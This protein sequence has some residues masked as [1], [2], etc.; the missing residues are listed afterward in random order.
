MPPVYAV[1]ARSCNLAADRAL[2]TALPDLSPEDRETALDTLV[3]RERGQGL[4]AVVARFPSFDAA[5]QALVLARADRL[6]AGVRA[7][8]DSGNIDTR[9]AAVELIRRSGSSKLAY[10]LAGALSQRCPRTRMRAGNALQQLVAEHLRQRDVTPADPA[11]RRERRQLAMAIRQA[12]ACWEAHF[13]T[14][15]ITAAMWLAEELEDVIVHRA[16]QPRSKLGRAFDELLRGGYDRHTTGYLLRALR[17]PI[18]RGKAAR[19]IGACADDTFML[20]LL[21]ELWVT[22][23][24]RM[25]KALSW[26]RRLAWL[27]DGIRPLLELDARR[28]EAAAALVGGVGITNDAKVGLLQTMVT[29]GRPALRRA[30]MWQLVGNRSPEAVAA[31]RCL[32]KRGQRALARVADRELKRRSRADLVTSPS[33]SARGTESDRSVVSTFDAYWTRFDRLDDARRAEFGRRLRAA[34]PD[35]DRQVRT[36]LASSDPADRVRSVQL[37]RAV[38]MADE[39]DNHLYGLAH[40]ADPLVRSVAMRALEALDNPAAR[41]ILRNALRDS[42][43]RV[44]ANAIEALDALEASEFHDDIKDKL[45]AP[46]ARVRASAVKLLLKLQRRE[47]V[48]A[49]LAMLDAAPRADRLGAVWVVERLRLQSLTDRLAELARVDPDP[50]VRRRAARVARQVGEA[51]TV[52]DW[53][54][55]SEVAGP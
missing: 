42:D 8:I 31:L 6:S 4:A 22:A 30:A 20:A 24:P 47:A 16:G 32:A 34:L 37:V 50:Q 5:L 27:E 21:D 35:F 14:E 12:L 41:R 44:Q 33:A 15:V 54:S 52:S 49:L 43:E 36:R 2:V 10:L 48:D 23:D 51:P 40:D 19:W 9:T 53:F 25:C 18:L 17:S 26:I 3:R 11:A 45:G 39:A 7:A 13:R 46:S 29:A 55:L 1:L 28:S 38:G